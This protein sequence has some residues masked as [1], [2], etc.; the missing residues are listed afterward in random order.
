MNVIDIEGEVF[1]SPSESDMQKAQDQIRE[2]FDLFSEWMEKYQYLIDLGKQLPFLSAQ[3]CVDETLL[4]GCQS[5]VWLIHRILDGRLYFKA[6]SDST[7]VSG[8]IALVIRVYNGRTPAEILASEPRFIVDIGLK[9]HLSPT[10]SN[11]LAA[12]LAHIQQQ[13][14]L[15]NTGEST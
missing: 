10:R 8:L 14:E 4:H 2:D 5:Q 3:Y 9:A 1:I 7:I 6:N 12:M 11:G 13:A 15:A